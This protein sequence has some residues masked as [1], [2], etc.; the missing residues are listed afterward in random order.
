MSKLIKKKKK[1]HVNFHE[2]HGQDPKNVAHLSDL[3]GAQAAF[4]TFWSVLN[5]DDLGQKVVAL[6]VG[7]IVP[8]MTLQAQVDLILERINAPLALFVNPCGT[9]LAAI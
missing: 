4:C 3:K 5:P 6:D 1:K 2:F 8:N 9:L 7:P